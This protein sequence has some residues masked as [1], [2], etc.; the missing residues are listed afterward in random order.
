MRLDLLRVPVLRLLLSRPALALFRGLTLFIFLYALAWGFLVPSRE[1]NLFTTAVFWSLFWPFF[2]VTT[3]ATVGNVFCTLC[4]LGFLGRNLP[5]LRLRP[6]RFLKNPYLGLVLFNVIAYWFVLYTFPG[7]WR[8]PFRTALFFGFFLL[9]SL[10]VNALF[11]GMTFCKYLCPIGTVNSAFN[12]VGMLWLATNREACNSC[13]KPVCA[14]SCPYELNPSTFDP[15]NTNAWCTYCL[16]CARSCEDVK[17]ELRSY[18]HSLFKPI[19]KPFAWEV[20]VYVV[21]LGAITFGMRYHHALGHTQLGQFMPWTLLGNFV[22]EKL[23]TPEWV[24]PVGFFAFVMALL[25]AFGLLFLSLKLAKRVSGLDERTLFLHLGYAFAPLMIIGALAHVSEFFFLHYYHNIVNGFA[26][27][28]GLS[29]R[30]EPLAERGDAWLHVFRVFP[31]LA[32]FWSLYILK[33]RVELLS[34]PNRT[35]LFAAAS[36]L[37][38]YYLLLSAVATV[39]GLFFRLPHGH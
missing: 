2:M 24:D 14:L 31:F 12:R 20:W 3:L 23:G 37:P 15:K 38:V 4:P 25:T 11:R 32:G 6:P 16:D 22:R 29:L 21:L 7:F 27:A 13:K 10:T 30:V 18:S 36:V 39:A 33:K 34:V 35:Q 28:F 26:Q 17:F 9:L 8:D 19:R 1:L 5:S